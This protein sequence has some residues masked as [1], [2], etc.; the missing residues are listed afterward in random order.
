[1]RCSEFATM[2]RML[3]TLSYSGEC[4]GGKKRLVDKPF[5]V[6]HARTSLIMK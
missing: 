5:S 1:M 3:S 4:Y 6:T 2:W